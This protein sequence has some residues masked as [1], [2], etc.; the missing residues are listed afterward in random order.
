MVI[1]H[2]E[3]RVQPV[4]INVIMVVPAVRLITVLLM[5]VVVVVLMVMVMVIVRLTSVPSD[6]VVGLN[7]VFVL[8]P[9][10]DVVQEAFRLLGP[11]ACLHSFAGRAGIREIQDASG[12]QSVELSQAD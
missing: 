1:E 6:P 2:L 3:E 11:P 12:S 5:L 9:V 10:G 8:V 4:G 7:T